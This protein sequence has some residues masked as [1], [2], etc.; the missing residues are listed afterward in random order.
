M[1]LSEA[2]LAELERIRSWAC[3]MEP[4]RRFM[5]EV[6]NAA[7]KRLRAYVKERWKESP[8]PERDDGYTILKNTDL[9]ALLADTLEHE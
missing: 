3:C 1:K 5:A 8:E 9:V 4:E 2:Q 7:L 6:E